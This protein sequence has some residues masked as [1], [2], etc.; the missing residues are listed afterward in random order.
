MVKNDNL[1]NEHG[2]ILSWIVLGVRAD[3]T[4]LDILDGQVLDVETNVVTWGG[5]VNLLV[6][7]LDGLDLGG[8]AD[9]A[10]GDDHTGLDDTGLD[11]ADWHG[12]DTTNLV[13]VLEGKSEG[14]VNWALGGG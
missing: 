3:V 5:L 4:S 1:G 7:H 2:V 13:D 6:M 8:G 10:E 9:W 14:L 12:T 11:T